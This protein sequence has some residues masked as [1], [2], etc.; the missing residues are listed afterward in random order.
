MPLRW[1]PVSLPTPVL[2]LNPESKYPNRRAY[3]L[4]ARGD[5][6]SNA[7]AGHLENLVAGRQREFAC[8]R[9]RL[10]LIANDCAAD[11]SEPLAGPTGGKQEGKT[12]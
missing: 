1:P 8:G 2:V 4:K 5:A 9:E 6:K 3:G 11:V 12:L 10:D 7:R